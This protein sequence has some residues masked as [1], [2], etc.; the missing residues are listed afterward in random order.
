MLV[1]WLHYR[2][3]S[4]HAEHRE[5]CVVTCGSPCCWVN[6][7]VDGLIQGNGGCGLGEHDVQKRVFEDLLERVKGQPGQFALDQVWAVLH[8]RFEFHVTV[9]TL[10]PGDQVEHVHTVRCL[11]FRLAG[12]TGELHGEESEHGRP[13]GPVPHLHQSCIK[14]HLACECADGQE[15]GC[16]HNEEWCHSLVEEL[17]DHLSSL[18]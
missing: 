12:P 5:Y 7:C 4:L 17:R 3:Q 16:A 1:G 9:S 14:I 13:G 6:K 10:P 11:A 8:D 2:D 18:F 15:G